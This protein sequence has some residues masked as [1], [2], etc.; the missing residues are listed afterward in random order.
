MASS[1]GTD[2]G[3]RI[4]RT[5][6]EI[7]PSQPV[8]PAAYLRQGFGGL[9]PPWVGQSDLPTTNP[10]R[11]APPRSARPVNGVFPAD[12]H[13]TQPPHETTARLDSSTPQ[14]SHSFVTSV[15]SS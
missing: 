9:A 10:I 6:L 2:G 5:A 12:A 11:G 4:E 8:D 1:F 15:A 7:A 14:R 3:R 13:T